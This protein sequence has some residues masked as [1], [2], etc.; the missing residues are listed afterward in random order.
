MVVPVFIANCHV[1]E[2]L[3]KGPVAAQAKMTR[4]APVKAYEL[5]AQ[6]VIVFENFSKKLNSFFLLMIR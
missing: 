2:K 6:E 1:S 5:P 3:K 4:K